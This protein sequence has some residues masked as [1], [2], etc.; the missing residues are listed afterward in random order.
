VFYLF[1]SKLIIGAYCQIK[2]N[3]VYKKIV[4]LINFV[5][6]SEPNFVSSFGYGDRVYFFFREM[7]VENT[8]C[9]KVGKRYQLLSLFLV[10]SVIFR[11]VTVYSEATGVCSQFM[12]IN[13]SMVTADVCET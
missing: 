5:Y 3:F 1:I 4:K 7:A 12:L 8:N 2:N 9:G 6:N 10:S 11:V 13:K